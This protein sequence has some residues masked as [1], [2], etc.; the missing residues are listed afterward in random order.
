[1]NAGPRRAFVALGSNLDDREAHLAYARD[2]LAAGPGLALLGASSVYETAPQGL[3]D[4]PSFL[5]Q[6]LAVE[7]VLEPLELLC[8][9]QRIETE[10]GR[11]REVRFGPRT[12]D[13]DILLIEGMVSGDPVLTVP[14]PRMLERAFVLVPLAEVWSYARGMPLIDVPALGRE[15]ARDQPIHRY[16]PPEA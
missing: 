15:L 9:C 2:A 7:T 1:V 8:V 13:V 5:N 6:V 4:Q 12:L 14:H 3:E 10:R 16:L 11:R